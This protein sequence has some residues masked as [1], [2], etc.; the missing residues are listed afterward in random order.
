MGLHL[1]TVN[2]SA[3]CSTA[4]T[5]EEEHLQE[6]ILSQMVQLQLFGDAKKA[7]CLKR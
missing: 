5:A 2:T 6:E 4:D 3:H 7:T 1:G